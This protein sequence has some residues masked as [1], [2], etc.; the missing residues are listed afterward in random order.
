MGITYLVSIESTEKGSIVKEKVIRRRSLRVVKRVA[1]KFA[2]TVQPNV[3]WGMWKKVP[4]SSYVDGVTRLYRFYLP[5][6][7]KTAFQIE[8]VRMPKKVEQD[9]KNTFS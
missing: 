5:E 9:E 8:L 6:Y 7:P 3:Q 1:M 4:G 2:N